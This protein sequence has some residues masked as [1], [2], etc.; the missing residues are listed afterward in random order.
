MKFA[1]TKSATPLLNT[2]DFANVFKY[3][4]P[5]DSKGLLSPVEMVAFA[6]TILVL[7]KQC[8]HWIYQVKMPNYPEIPLYTDSR[9]L[10]FL[11]TLPKKSQKRFL[12]KEI[13]IEKLKNLVGNIYIWG[14]NWNLGI[15]ELL[16]FY[17]PKFPLDLLSQK[18]WTLEGID[19]SGLLYQV[20]EG[21][22]PRNTSQ[23]IHFGCGLNIEG[24]TLELIAEQLEPLDV[25]VWSGHMVIVL[26]N[27][28]IIESSCSKGG[29]IIT[30]LK[31]RLT[32]ILQEKKPANHWKGQ[33]TFTI[34]RWI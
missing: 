3:P 16:E 26:D 11:D 12:S 10:K 18:R 7:L 21:F 2:E 15:P 28:S 25:I 17:P 34:R 9:F 32:E 23:I 1:I 24:M 31:T 14:G 6:G 5:L 33:E 29:V 20:T 30:D 27:S 13:L 19:C 4:L 8:N 22:T